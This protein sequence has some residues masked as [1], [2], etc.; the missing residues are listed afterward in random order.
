MKHMRGIILLTALILSGC[1]S[2]LPPRYHAL[3]LPAPPQ[4][5]GSARMLVEILPIAVPERLNREEMVL[6]GATGQLDVRE[7][8]RWAAA[9]PDEIRQIVTDTLWRALQAADVYRVPVPAETATPQYRLALRVERFEAV[10]GKAA[11]VEGSWTARRL[12]RGLPVVCRANF[13]VALPDRTPEAAAAALAL[14]TG[15][16]A[17]ALADS[18]DRLSQDNGA[19]CAAPP[20]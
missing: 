8:D 10:M 18:I 5:S 9:L 2:S 17:R 14:G 15:Q 12:P 4:T 19:A 7:N 3:S 16:L 20:S 6:T 11:L 13:T 1:G